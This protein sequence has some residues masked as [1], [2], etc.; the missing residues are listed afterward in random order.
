MGQADDAIGSQE[1]DTAI[2]LLTAAVRKADPAKNLDKANLA[3]YNLSFCYFMNKQYLRG[4]RA[5]RAPS[6]AYPQGGLGAKSTEI[7]MQAWPMPT[8][9]TPNVDRVSDLNRLIDLANYTA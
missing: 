3:R 8:R 1:W 2:A 7:G 9:P 6:P 5:G 4:R